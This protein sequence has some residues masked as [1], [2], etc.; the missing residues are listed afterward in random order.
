MGSDEKL[1]LLYCPVG[2][3]THDLPHNPA[4]KMVNVSHA[5]NHSATAAVLLVYAR[6]SKRS[7]QSVQEMC[8]LSRTPPLLEKDNSKNNSVF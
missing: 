7:H 3:Q 6:R 8:N 5:H 2:V 4:S 1:I